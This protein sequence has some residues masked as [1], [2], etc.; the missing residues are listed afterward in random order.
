[1]HVAAEPK[2]LRLFDVEAEGYGF[3]DPWRFVADFG[4]LC[5]ARV[6]YQGKLTGKFVEDVRNGRYDVMEGV[7]A[8]GGSGGRD[9]WMCKIKTLAYMERLRQAFADR[10]EDF[11]E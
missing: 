8:R 1:M 6:V 2:E 3:V 7:I 11:W 5:S 9:V 10:W 4:M